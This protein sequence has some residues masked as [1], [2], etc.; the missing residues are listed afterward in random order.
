[1]AKYNVRPTDPLEREQYAAW[2]ICKNTSKRN[3]LEWTITFEDYKK[4]W[5]D[6]WD[7]HGGS[8]GCLVMQR[9]D[10]NKGW[11]AG[12]YALARKKAKSRTYQDPIKQSQYTAWMRMKAQANFRNERWNLSFDDF[13][14]LWTPYWSQRGR[15]NT[16][17][18]LSRIDN[19]HPWKFNNVAAIKRSVHL[20]NA[21][22]RGRGKNKSAS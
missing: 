5:K 21:P 2:A 12:N 15:K 7:R 16:D 11:I 13:L 3:N 1:M 18:C 8:T 22:R 10:L 4:M 14:V 6:K 17:Y 9:N 20:A 19:T